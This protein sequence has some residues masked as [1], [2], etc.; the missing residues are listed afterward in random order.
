MMDNRFD[1]NQAVDE[2]NL[3]KAEIAYPELKPP[4][5]IQDILSSLLSLNKLKTFG[6]VELNEYSVLL[7][8]YALFLTNQENKSKTEINWCESNIKHIVGR[9]LINTDGYGFVEK[10]HRIRSTHDV[11]KKLEAKKLEAQLKIDYIQN[12]SLKLHHIT[13]TLKNLAYEKARQRREG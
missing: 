4:E 8:A 10:D 5:N 3:F 2:L 9:E 13:E 11:A 12:M 7:S 1:K 6:P